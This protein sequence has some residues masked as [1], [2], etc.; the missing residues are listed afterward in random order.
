M[1]KDKSDLEWIQNGILW[2]VFKDNKHKWDKK[3]NTLKKNK[4]IFSRL[5]PAPL[6]TS[7]GMVVV[8]LVLLPKGLQNRVTNTLLI[9]RGYWMLYENNDWH[10]RI[11]NV[12]VKTSV[13][14]GK[15]EADNSIVHSLDYLYF[16]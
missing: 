11:I 15:V 4:G 7:V 16:N 5:K 8:R 9:Q 1:V 6:F 13:I 2:F 14:T 10:D 12:K 3:I